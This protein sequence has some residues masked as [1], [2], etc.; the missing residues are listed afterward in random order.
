MDTHAGMDG[1][2][3][4]AP[5][6]ITEASPMA[7]WGKN[8]PTMRETRILSVGQEDPLEKKTATHS[9]VPV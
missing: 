3:S 5:E 4:C 6:S 9:S 2:L 7:P 8:P 1:L